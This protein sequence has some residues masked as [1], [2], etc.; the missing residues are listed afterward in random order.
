MKPTDK[1]LLDF[2][3]RNEAWVTYASRQAGTSKA[4]LCQITARHFP[5][6]D[7]RER[8][9]RTGYGKTLREA[10]TQAMSAN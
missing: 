2:I 10:V 1:E 7:I 6:P 3:E 9:A 8:S 5:T 4:W